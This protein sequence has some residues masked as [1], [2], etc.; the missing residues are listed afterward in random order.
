[1]CLPNIISF[2][3]VSSI[4]LDHMP[5][6]AIFYLL[7]SWDNNVCLAAF[8][9]QYRSRTK[10]VPGTS[11]QRENKKGNVNRLRARVPVRACVN[12]SMRRALASSSSKI[13]SPSHWCT[14]CFA[15][16]TCMVFCAGFDIIYWW[17][18]SQ[19]TCADSFLS[20]VRQMRAHVGERQ[21]TFGQALQSFYLSNY[22][23]TELPF[24]GIFILSIDF[25][26]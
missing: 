2:N 5:P 7:D 26:Q 6:L 16:W 13:Y 19:D 10:P 8:A 1:M 24:H 14:R 23:C 4:L 9:C 20:F 3:S 12:L 21:I 11:N 17:A 25:W 15:P 22:S 18:T